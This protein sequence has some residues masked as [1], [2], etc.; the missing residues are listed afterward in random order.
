M[1]EKIKVDCKNCIFY[2]Q[3]IKEKNQRIAE[4]EE[5]NSKMKKKLE[6]PH[7]VWVEN[8][9]LTEINNWQNGE[10]SRLHE[11]LKNAIVPKLREGN[12]YYAVCKLSATK[13]CPVCK[14]LYEKEI[15]QG[16]FVGM[17]KCSNCNN[18]KVKE[19]EYCIIPITIESAT[20]YSNGETCNATVNLDES[21]IK[22]KCTL[23]EIGGG[24]C[25]GYDWFEEWGFHV[26]HE[27][28][29]FPTKAE[30]QKYLEEHK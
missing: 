18:G 14:G 22:E 13:E 25:Y 21:I 16:N 8:N 30:A 26:N 7:D 3:K 29:I 12:M 17:M 6:N 4:L 20:Y 2:E 15:E 24:V 19:C 1:K 28:M 27:N 23:S 5:E 10:I 11:Q 9:T